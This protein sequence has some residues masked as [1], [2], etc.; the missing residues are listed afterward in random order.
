MQRHSRRKR[1]GALEPAGGELDL[2][3]DEQDAA[4]DVLVA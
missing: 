3:R 4:A 2:A 1:R